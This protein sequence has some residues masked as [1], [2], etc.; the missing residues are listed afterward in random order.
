MSASAGGGGSVAIYNNNSRT[1]VSTTFT[2]DIY[3]RRKYHKYQKISV[4]KPTTTLFYL[5]ALLKP[6][7][8]IE[9]SLMFQE[10]VNGEYNTLQLNFFDLLSV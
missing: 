6:S 5:A 7:E 10:P 8:H 9:H 4:R 1:P 3:P 2:A